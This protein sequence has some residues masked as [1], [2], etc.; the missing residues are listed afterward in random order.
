MGK[1]K[2]HLPKIVQTNIHLNEHRLNIRTICLTKSFHK[3][4]NQPFQ[5]DKEMQQYLKA[6]ALGRKTELESFEVEMERIMGAYETRILTK[7]QKYDKLFKMISSYK[8]DNSRLDKEINNLNIDVCHLKMT[9]NSE[10]QE[11]EQEVLKIR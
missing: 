11:K 2:K 6:K 1:T 10:L 8:K 3:I 7:K 4:S 5:L 9:R